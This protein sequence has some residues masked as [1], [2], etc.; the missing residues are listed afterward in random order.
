[1]DFDA[2]LDE[3]TLAET[4]V[5]ICLNGKLRAQYARLKARI[6]ERAAAA[7]EA[8]K[9]LGDDRLADKGPTPDPEQPELDRL[10]E[11]MRKYT[12]EVVLRALPKEEWNE[13]FAKHPPRA[14]KQTGKRNP[15]DMIGVNYDSFFP[16]LVRETIVSPEMTGDRWQKFYAKLSDAQFNKL[17]NAAWDINQTED[18]V[19]FSLG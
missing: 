2:M 12:V 4:T 17:A 1:M 10:V 11:Q 14:D 16:T 7:H 8:Q 18:D 19:P 15:R 9:L 13:L 3:A 6:D 5:P